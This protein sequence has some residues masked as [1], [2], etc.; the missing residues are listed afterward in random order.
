MIKLLKSS[1]NKLIIL[2]VLSAILIVLTFF[3]ETPYLFGI[4]TLIIAFANIRKLKFKSEMLRGLAI[5]TLYF[6][7]FTLTLFP[8][9]TSEVSRPVLYIGLALIILILEGL[10]FYKKSIN[11]KYGNVLDEIKK[12]EEEYK[13]GEIIEVK[14]GEVIPADGII[15]EGETLVNESSITGNENMVG[16]KFNDE[17]IG[18]TVNMKNRIVIKITQVNENSVISQMKDLIR[19]NEKEKGTLQKNT[20]KAENILGIIVLI[21]SLGVLVFWLKYN[22]S[23]FIG[24]LSMCSVLLIAAPEIFYNSAEIPIKY[25]INKSTKKGI[26]FKGGRVIE[27]LNKVTRILF[28]K[29]K[30][31]T[32]GEP[33]ITNVIPKEAFN[34]KRF[35][36]LV[37]SLES[38]SAHPFAQAITEYCEKNKISYKKA[39]DHKII[40]GMGVIGMLDNQEIIVGNSKLMEKYHVKLYGNLLQKADV[41][42]KNLR[43]PVYV[44]RNRELIGIIGITDRIKEHA[45]EGISKLKKYKLTLITGDDKQIAQGLSNELRIKEFFSDLDEMEKLEALKNYRENNDIVA[46]VGHGKEDKDFLDEADVGIAL[47]SYTELFEESNDVTLIS[48]DLSKISEVMVYAKNI[49]EK[50]K[51][52]FLYTLLYHL[53]LLPIAGGLFIPFTGLIM[54]PAE[55]ALLMSLLF[56]VIAKN[57]FNLQLDK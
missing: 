36:I 29:R 28:G 37:G 10:N 20:K 26:Y 13:I 9:L 43:T 49:N 42:S 53:I 30:V 25:G 51:Q 19:E 1:R 55:A 41:M 16:K 50:T 48:D 7:S 18:T 23:A 2:A 11:K 22:G 6:Y 56:V 27:K 24:I 17:V 33:E 12:V 35:L 44:A 52:N 39:Q 21:I 54:H 4:L 34:E 45:K 57:S 47:G 40:A 38:L 8:T 31:I 5:I 15:I 32:K 14:S 46:C 3:V